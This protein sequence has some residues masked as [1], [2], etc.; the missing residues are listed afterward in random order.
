M[1]ADVKVFDENG[2][3]DTSQR[4]TVRWQHSANGAGSYNGTEKVNVTETAA[5][6]YMTEV[7][8]AAQKTDEH[9]LILGNDSNTT[10]NPYTVTGRS[11]S[12]DTDAGGTVVYTNARET[13]DVA[14]E[15]ELV[16]NTATVSQF[17]FSASYTLDGVTK[18]LGSFYV[19]GGSANTEAL[20]EVPAG[21]VL[22]ITE[23]D[24]SKYDTTVKTA[25][26]GFLLH[27]QNKSK[28]IC[29]KDRL[30]V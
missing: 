29:I 7:T 3:E 17:S 18:D 12:F 28:K 15:K 13:K 1:Q 9:P 25:A 22:T 19:S 4:K 20:K 11:I 2:D 26:R 30:S 8:R 27:K 6:Y 10:D 21:A 23:A 14:V 16:S 24:D 5:D